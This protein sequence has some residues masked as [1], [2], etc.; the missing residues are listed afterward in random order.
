M[1]VWQD[2]ISLLRES[3]LIQGSIT[4]VVTLVAMWCVVTGTSPGQE[5][6]AFFGLILGFYF[7]SKSQQGATNAMRE[8]LNN[9]HKARE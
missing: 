6:W 8:A 3:V 5:F 7:G 2:L 4:L 9:V 1:T